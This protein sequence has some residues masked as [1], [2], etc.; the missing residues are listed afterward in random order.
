MVIVNVKKSI[1]NYII[2]KD[3]FFIVYNYAILNVKFVVLIMIHV[4]Y[5][6]LILIDM[7]FMIIVTVKWG[8]KKIKYLVNWIVY[9]LIFIEI[10]KI[11][12]NVNLII[13]NLLLNKNIVNV[14]WI[15]INNFL[16]VENMII[17]AYVI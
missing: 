4:K 6:N 9:V 11:I 1:T 8:L 3:P 2:I 5:V 10:M 7:I 14:A 12:V 16:V 15:I 17:I 13:W